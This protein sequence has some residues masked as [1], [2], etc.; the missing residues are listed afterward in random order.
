VTQDAGAIYFQFG[1]GVSSGPMYKI[2][3]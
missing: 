2:A 1:A 3:K